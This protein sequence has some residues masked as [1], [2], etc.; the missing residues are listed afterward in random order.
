MEARTV[1]SSLVALTN[2]FKDFG[3][4]P[5]ALSSGYANSSERL[6]TFPNIYPKNP[7]NDAEMKI[8]NNFNNETIVFGFAIGFPGSDN[9]VMVK[10]RANARKMKEL[11]GDIEEEE[12]EEVYGEE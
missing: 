10:Y 2:D 9:K 5:S 4:A 12:D 6:T 8:A 7:S 11:S 1:I 3:T